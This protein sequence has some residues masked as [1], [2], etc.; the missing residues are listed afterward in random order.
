[1]EFD[2]F[3]SE[4]FRKD[5]PTPQDLLTTNYTVLFRE[6]FEPGTVE[7][8][9]CETLSSLKYCL[10]TMMSSEIREQIGSNLAVLERAGDQFELKSPMEFKETKRKKPVEGSSPFEKELSSV[11]EKIKRDFQTL[12][13]KIEAMMKERQ[14]EQERQE[15]ETNGKGGKS[16]SLTKIDSKYVERINR[17]SGNPLLEE[18]VTSGNSQAGI[19]NRHYANSGLGEYWG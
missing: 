4:I 15:M 5:K 13:K 18:D 16:S 1:M 12:N 19:G 10:D 14:K 3:E 9:I 8:I 17:R 7:Y 2:G 6:R 11:L